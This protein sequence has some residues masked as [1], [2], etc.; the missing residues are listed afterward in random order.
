MNIVQGNFEKFL[1]VKLNNNYS[2]TTSLNN[3]F[4]SFAEKL[5]SFSRIS[6]NSNGKK[7]SNSTQKTVQNVETFSISITLDSDTSKLIKVDSKK[8]LS[9]INS[10]LENSEKTW[11]TDELNLLKSAQK[12]L[13]SSKTEITDKEI[14]TLQKALGLIIEDGVK[15]KE[16]PFLQET[17]RILSGENLPKE[18]EDVLKNQPTTPSMN[19]EKNTEKTEQNKLNAVK[20][21]NT[22]IILDK[23]NN[24]NVKI[25]TKKLSALFNDLSKNSNNL[26]N[27]QIAVL[28]TAKDILTSSETNLSQEEQEVIKNAFAILLKESKAFENNQNLSNKSNSKQTLNL[29][30]NIEEVILESSIFENPSASKNISSISSIN[31]LN[32][33]ENTHNLSNNKNDSVNFVKINNELF[34]Q[35]TQVKDKNIKD[36]NLRQSKDNSTDFTNIKNNQKTSYIDPYET[37]KN[38]SN[39][40]ESVEEKIGNLKNITE[41]SHDGSNK[42]F[43]ID[44]LKVSTSNNEVTN[45]TP[46][47]NKNTINQEI[48]KTNLNDLN[49]QIKDVVVSK[50]T[51]TFFNE[52]FSVKISPPDLGKVD[53]QIVKNG[54]AVTITISAESENTKNIISKSLQ[55]LVGSLRDEGYQPVNI[56]INLSQNE[57]YLA[58][59]NPQEQS[60]QEKNESDAQKHQN[61]E[62]QEEPTQNFEEYLRSDLNA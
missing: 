5:R 1:P 2:S 54:Q 53:V 42:N 21:A 37:R 25:D 49:T 39:K 40:S 18:L 14:A 7:I 10:L 36:N 6:D 35:F 28:E 4:D 45:K 33:K 60:Q 24:K 23:E 27:N 58:H 32:F 9:L 16:A 15:S 50:N 48:P 29:D 43:N 11:D 41:N 26:N 30:L 44:N 59:Q 61:N 62:T 51:Q 34:N 3:D 52:S 57:N 12:I 38:S 19:I 47:I 46:I 13:N 8:L 55:T 22:I 56:K 20:K 31:N 17:E